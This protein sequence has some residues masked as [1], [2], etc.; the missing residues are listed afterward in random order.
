MRSPAT[1]RREDGAFILTA[2]LVLL[3]LLGFIGFALDFGRLFVVKS[4]LQTA[5]DSCALAAAQELDGQSGAQQRAVNAGLNAGNSNSV[6][7]QSADWSGKGRLTDAEISFRDVNYVSTTSD[8]AARYAECRHIQPAVQMWLL[9]AMGAFS[10]S[11]GTYPNTQDVGASAVATRASAQSTCP[12][13]LALKP[14]AG[15]NAPNYGFTAGEWI[16]LLYQ[17]NAAQGG[18][19]GWANLDGSN[20]ASETESEMKGHCGTRVGDTLGTP[21]VQTSIADAWNARFGIY[22][23]NSG[24]DRPNMNPD[25]SGYAYTAKNWPT[26]QNAYGDFAAKRAAYA[27]CGSNGQVKGS[28]NS[29]EGITGLSLNS[30]QKLAT[31]GPA[32]EMHQYGANRRIVTVPV[33]DPSYK[34]ID[35]ACMLLLQPMP[36]PMANVQLEFIGNAGAANSPCTTSGQ[37][38]GSAGPLVP[39]LVR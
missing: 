23:N 34:V 4:E 39:V 26:Q 33:V 5:V 24:P 38:G 2:A 6:N 20:N 29:C 11:A 7:F 1:P 25:F 30:F 14:K 10:G 18:Q 12:I 19:I 3:F 28:A 13:P 16:T 22:K 8:A 21:G 27:A 35:Y 31:A 36:I 9:Q 15:G 32:G 37:P 17:Q